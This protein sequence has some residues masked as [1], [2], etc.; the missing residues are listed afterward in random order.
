MLH[1]HGSTSGNAIPRKPESAAITQHLTGQIPHKAHK[2]RI[3]GTNS[4]PRKVE[5]SLVHRT[6]RAP[7]TPE[8]STPSPAVLLSPSAQTR[9]I[10][11]AQRT[12]IR[13][14]TRPERPVHQHVVVHIPPRHP[15]HPA[16]LPHQ[17]AGHHQCPNPGRIRATTHRSQL[18]RVKTTPGH[19]R[20]RRHHRRPHVRTA[21]VRPLVL[22]HP[23]HLLKTVIGGRI[24]LEHQLASQNA[25]TVALPR[26]NP[27]HH[28]RILIH[29][30]HTPTLTTKETSHRQ[31]H[32]HHRAVQRPHTRRT[33]P[34][35]PSPT[36]ST[37]SKA[38]HSQTS[39]QEENPNHQTNRQFPVLH[40][41]NVRVDRPTKA[42]ANSRQK[43]SGVPKYSR[44]PGTK[45]HRPPRYHAESLL[46]PPD[47]SPNDGTPTCPTDCW[48]K[49]SYTKGQ[50][51]SNHHP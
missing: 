32:R 41:N 11:P 37:I 22:Y 19:R 43:D 33:P 14:L 45:L 21:D 7:K 48:A 50:S 10:Q 51:P 17:S 23:D 13:S 18:H 42:V 27:A 34:Q 2:S 36:P 38:E 46:P 31:H 8:N 40:P 9:N 35:T 30:P 12:V 1:P 20:R 15:P 47:P 16:I 39:P 25:V 5:V 6:H 24:S 29:P 44:T 28:L 4:A 3:R 49:N 26:R